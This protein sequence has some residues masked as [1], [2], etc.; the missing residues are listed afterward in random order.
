M[1]IVNCHCPYCMT[2]VR[3]KEKIEIETFDIMGEQISTRVKSLACLNC[4]EIFNNKQYPD[5][6]IRSAF[7]KYRRLHKL[8]NPLKFQ[9]KRIKMNLTHKEIAKLLKVNEKELKYFEEGA[10]QSFILNDK[11]NLFINNRKLKHHI[12]NM[13]KGILKTKIETFLKQK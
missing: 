1:K 7:D 5:T 8:I 6:S 12:K 4:K 11:I 10:L 9:D 13:K 2:K 3:A